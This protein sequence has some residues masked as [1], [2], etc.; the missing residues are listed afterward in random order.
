M[1]N[2]C[3]RLWVVAAIREGNARTT[4]NRPDHV[5]PSVRL[6]AQLTE[7]T[8]LASADRVALDGEEVSNAVLE[9]EVRAVRVDRP[10]GRSTVAAERVDLAVWLDTQ[11]TS[12]VYVVK[13]HLL[14]VLQ[15]PVV[16]TGTSCQAGGKSAQHCAQETAS[17]LLYW[18]TLLRGVGGGGGGSPSLWCSAVRTWLL[19]VLRLLRWC[20]V[21]W[22][23][24]ES[25]PWLRWVLRLCGWVA[26]LLR[27]VLRLCCRVAW[28]LRW[29]AWLG[30]RCTVSRL[31]WVL[32]WLR[33]VLRLAWLWVAL[34]W[35]LWVS[36]VRHV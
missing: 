23:W 8:T 1:P 14:T 27:R 2:T 30:R 29:V 9:L 31:R 13:V 12:S 3:C 22:C 36:W 17:A 35:L 18:C 34:L 10:G 4:V 21:S 6:H 32:A 28:L 15:E 33:R 5:G 20:A 26:W 16:T 24:W 19:R 25:V 7:P 11:V